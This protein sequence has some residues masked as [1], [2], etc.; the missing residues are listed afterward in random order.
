LKIVLEG[1]I[2]GKKYRVRPKM[3]YYEHIMKDKKTKSY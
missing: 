2:S 3:E 1:D